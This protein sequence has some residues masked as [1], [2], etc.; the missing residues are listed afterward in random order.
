MFTG[1]IEHVGLVVRL[2]PAG[3]STQ[4][5]I[6]LGPVWGD[7][8]LGESLAVDGVC[9]T[10]SCFEGSQASFDVSA[11]TLGG[12][13]LGGDGAGIGVCVEL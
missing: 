3:R 6:D 7:L 2:G 4:L 11:T 13:T 9:L 5:R 10:V 8:K 12:T 1:L